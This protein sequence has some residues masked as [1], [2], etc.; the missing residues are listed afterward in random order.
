[1]NKYQKTLITVTTVASLALALPALADSQSN[2]K[3]GE[4]GGLF[5]PV[6]RMGD[7]GGQPGRPMMG[8]RAGQPDV[9]GKVT[10][11][12]GT[13]LTVQSVKR[14]VR[15]ES[16][17]TSTAPSVFTVDA[18]NARVLKAN[19]TSTLSDIAVGDNIIVQGKLSGTN[20]TAAIIHDAPAIGKNN[21]SR[22]S[23]LMMQGNGQPVVIGDIT[24]VNGNSIVIS[25]KSNVSYTVDVSSA[26]IL[27]QGV[28]GTTT[29]SNLVVGD[30]VIVQGVI[31]GNSVSASSVIDRGVSP[32]TDLNA[33]TT[34]K[35][36]KPGIVS[37][38]FSS[39]GSFFSRLFGF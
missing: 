36:A 27:K 22:G 25:N 30:G 20:V 31:N 32:T 18:S 24:S 10:A 23:E 37:G 28:T 14:G 11:I 26:S 19:A 39:V 12:N 33:S 8:N 13:T 34:T 21:S 16:A 9:I 5:N 38:I 7:N 3:G 35:Q 29:V 4:M 2:Q 6:A 1:M 17:S 15:V